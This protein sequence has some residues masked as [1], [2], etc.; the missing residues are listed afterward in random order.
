[1]CLAYEDNALLWLAHA[2][3]VIL[4]RL[5]AIIIATLMRCAMDA[6]MHTLILVGSRAGPYVGL[7]RREADWLW[8]CRNS[9]PMSHGTT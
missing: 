7:K 8:L 1:M 6:G 5:N 4:M 2:I 3:L 9:S